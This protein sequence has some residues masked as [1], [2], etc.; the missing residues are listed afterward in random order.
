MIMNDK[1]VLKNNLKEFRIEKNIAI[2][3]SLV[4]L[5]RLLITTFSCIII[6]KKFSSYSFVSY[7]KQAVVIDIIQTLILVM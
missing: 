2:S 1:L 4:V 6:N 5:Q 3:A 7:I